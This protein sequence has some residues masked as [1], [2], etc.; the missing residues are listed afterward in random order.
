MG[1]RYSRY[2]YFNPY[3]P[4]YNPYPVHQTIVNPPAVNYV[5]PV[6]SPRACTL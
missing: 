3:V 6:I 5:P 2:R 1:S 4:M